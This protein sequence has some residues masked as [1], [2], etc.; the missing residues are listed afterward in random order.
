MKITREALQSN[1]N[2]RSFYEKIMFKTDR[3][4][5]TSNVRSAL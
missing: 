2:M 3:R 1:L 4:I 5:E